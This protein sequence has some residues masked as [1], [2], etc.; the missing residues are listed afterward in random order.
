MANARSLAEQETVIRFDR[1]STLATCWTAA[2]AVSRKWARLGYPVR[3]DGAGWR[4]EVPIKALTF[5]R[6]DQKPRQPRKVASPPGFLRMR[7]TGGIETTG[8]TR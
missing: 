6:L 1:A 4:A 3:A 5:R 7:S 2:P 8:A